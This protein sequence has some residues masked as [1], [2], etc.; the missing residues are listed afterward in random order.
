MNSQSTD[1]IRQ[2][3]ESAQLSHNT[4]THYLKALADSGFPLYYQVMEGEPD[5][6]WVD[7]EKIKWL[8]KTINK[9]PKLGLCI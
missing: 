5:V 4:T 2:V 1:E 6:Y 3:A 7:R 9:P 8:K